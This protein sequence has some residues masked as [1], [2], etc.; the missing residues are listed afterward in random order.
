[1]NIAC[2]VGDWHGLR[3]LAIMSNFFDELSNLPDRFALNKIAA[4][5]P[6]EERTMLDDPL[7]GVRL[8]LRL[9]LDLQIVATD[10]ELEA[11]PLLNIA[12]SHFDKVILILAFV[13][14][15]IEDYRRGDKRG[16]PE[17]FRL[18]L[19]LERM[20]IDTRAMLDALF[21]LSL[22]YQPDTDRVRGNKR[23]SFGKFCDWLDRESPEPFT[24]PLGHMIEIVP[25][26]QD[27]R[28]LRDGYVHHGH[29]SFVFFGDTELYFDASAHLHSVTPRALPDAFYAPDNPNNLIIVEKF[30]VF[31]VAPA[32][33]CRRLVG[34]SLHAILETVPGWRHMGAGMPYREGSGIF[35]MR[36]WL[37]RNTDALVPD[38]FKSRHFGATRS[39]TAL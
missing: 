30:L 32:L 4:Q 18:P 36:E 9:N 24:G 34:N 10:R 6:V 3:G 33:A 2:A 27:I 21:R 23:E 39:A 37:I 38:I 20:L 8:D 13:L 1:M 28:T 12:E 29:E 25:W 31:V 22:L 19:D 11:R 35:R 14:D 7:T 26:A 15:D 5:R 17:R 16:W